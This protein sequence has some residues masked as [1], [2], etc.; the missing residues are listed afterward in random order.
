MECLFCKIAS[1]EIPAKIV[2][3]TDELL[4]FRDIEP[5][6]PVHILIIPKQHI[7][8]TKELTNKNATIIGKMA[9]LAKE[10]CKK[11][12]IED[13]NRWVINTGIEGGQTVFHIHLHI[14]GGRTMEWPPG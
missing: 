12:N 5:Q 8:S 4:A 3:E 2:A 1:K 10:I 6:S 14:L 13:G 9:F 11:E 7:S